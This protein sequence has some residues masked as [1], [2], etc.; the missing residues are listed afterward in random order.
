LAVYGLLQALYTQQD[1]VFHLCKAL[2]IQNVTISPDWHE[3]PEIRNVR[4]VR[5]TAIGHPTEAGRREPFSYHFIS[6]VTLTHHGFD[7][8]SSYSDGRDV[9]Q[10]VSLHDL[11]GEQT[12]HLGQILDTVIDELTVEAAGH[13]ARFQGEEMVNVFPSGL[14]YGFQNLFQA[15]NQEPNAARVALAKGAVAQINE[16]LNAFSEAASRRGLAES[17][18]LDWTYE[19]YALSVLDEYFDHLLAG[20]E[21]KIDYRTAR[22]FVSFLGRQIDHLRA[23]ASEIDENFAT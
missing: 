20:Q 2:K 12:D 19:A 22:I 16:V 9:W 21:S 7:L 1:A 5:N 13:R 11:I 6:R 3:F 15:T 14:P 18:H 17:L 8:Q 10:T 23:T 4:N